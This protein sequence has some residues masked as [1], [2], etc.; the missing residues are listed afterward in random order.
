MLPLWRA[1][2]NHLPRSGEEIGAGALSRLAEA[3]G[4]PLLGCHGLPAASSAR[5]R[6]RT[7]ARTNSAKRHPPL[8]GGQTNRGLP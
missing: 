3:R 5:V 1:A 7:M 8:P 2:R 6:S 4:V